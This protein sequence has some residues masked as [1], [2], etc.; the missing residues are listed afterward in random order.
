MYEINSERNFLFK[1]YENKERKKKEETNNARN[2][3][4]RLEKRPMAI[5][6]TKH[7]TDS[8]ASKNLPS[9]AQCLKSSLN[10]SHKIH[11]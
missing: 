10:H 7:P 11:R 6:H 4:I 9:C 3:N 2:G 5:T 8:I 1:F